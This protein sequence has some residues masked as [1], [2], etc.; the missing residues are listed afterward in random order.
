LPFH[1]LS[2]FIARLETEGDLC[3]IAAEVDP[4][5]EIAAITDR[6]SK[7]AGGNKA[8]LFERVKGHPFPVLTNLFGSLDR[9]ASALGADDLEAL[10]RRLERDLAAA[11]G[12]SAGQRLRALVRSPAWEPCVIETPPCREIV[13]DAPDL[14]LLPALQ[15]WPGD[16]G[17]YLTLPLVFT[18]DPETG[19]TNCGMYRVQIV[20]DSTALVHW[21]EGSGGAAHHAAW[22]RRGEPMPVAIA[23]GGPPA[24][25]YAAG[26]PLPEGVEETRFA[27]YLQGEPVEM[28]ACLS[29]GLRVPAAA[30]FVIE[31]FIDPGKTGT[32]GPFGNHTGSYAPAGPFPLLRVSALCHR[33]GPL[34][35]ATIVGPPPMEDCF[36]G[37]ATE[38]LF[39]PLLR[40]EVLGVRDI[41]LPIEGIFHGCALVS[42]R[43]EGAD[44][45]KELLRQLWETG[46]LKRSK[47][48]VVLDEDV[49][50]QDPS[51]CYW[52][53]LNQVDPGRD[54]IVEDGRLGIDAT[55]RENGARVGT[56]PET[57]RLLARR[58]E[59]YG[60]G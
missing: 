24:L 37:K 48:I 13:R 50:V 42:A 16:G 10:A 46:L 2:T 54:L 59:E 31:G 30:E 4:L 15:S 36:L 12:E 58:W 34:F 1:D 32:E 56:D 57:Q 33:R 44:G 5:L 18:A 27:G 29:S 9:T 6:V 3:R 14:C 11:P 55:H 25:T 8:L 28:A 49:D 47:M 51:L 40:L 7:G 19:E 43:T 52:R 17:R 53:A 21:K 38:R 60:I 23:L 35:P 45:G 22:Q 20:D 41:N 26:A 39:L